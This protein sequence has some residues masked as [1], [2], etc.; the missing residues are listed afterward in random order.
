[1][2]KD[3]AAGLGISPAM[4]TKLKKRGMPTISVEAAAKWRRRHL[5]P[6]RTVGMRAGTTPRPAVAAAGN[7]SKG[8][9][10]GTR[11]EQLLRQAEDLGLLAHDALLRGSFA[12]VAPMLRRAMAQ[13][14]P[15]ARCQIGLTV[16]VW[17]AL[18]ASIPLSLEVSV[19]SASAGDLPD[20]VMGEFWMLVA[21]GEYASIGSTDGSGKD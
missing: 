9:L 17:D 2:L 7:V 5:E 4:V 6:A 3:L 21:L 12:V 8:Q 14:P 1:M 15:D 16:E 19:E 20:D 18:T 10:V 11:T 13:V